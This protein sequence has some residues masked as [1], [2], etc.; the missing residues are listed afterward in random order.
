[1]QSEFKGILITFD[2][3]NAQELFG[4]SHTGEIW[5]QIH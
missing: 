3:L 5:Q 1:M 4:L 2:A